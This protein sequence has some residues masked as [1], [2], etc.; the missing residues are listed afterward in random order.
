[1]YTFDNPSFHCEEWIDD[2][3][4]ASSA[5]TSTKGTRVVFLAQT[6][7]CSEINCSPAK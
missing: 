5:M 2:N 4:L 1:M 6:S 7:Q 3:E